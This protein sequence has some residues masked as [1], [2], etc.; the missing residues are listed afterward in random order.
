MKGFG[1]WQRMD[2]LERRLRHDRPVPP[3]ELLDEVVRRLEGSR[4]AR[5]TRTTV[6]RLGLAGAAAAMMLAVFAAFGGVGLAASGASNAASSTVDAILTVAK[7]AK[8]KPAKPKT[9]S[10]PA[11]LTA[12]QAKPGQPTSQSVA[13]EFGN[14]GHQ[15]SVSAANGQYCPPRVTICH[16]GKETLTLPITAAESHL[17][18]HRDDYSGPCV[19]ATA[20]DR[21]RNSYCVSSG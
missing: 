17:R 8:A 9:K 7:P 16:N 20:D 10:V 11:K 4:P 3:D 2:G 19:L 5:S 18:N 1:R 15:D 6:R 13:D 14:C 12:V 21:A